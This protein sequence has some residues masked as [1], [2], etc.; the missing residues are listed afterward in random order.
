MWQKESFT[1]S[2]GTGK[3]S[4]AS[5]QSIFLNCGDME[6]FGFTTPL[7]SEKSVLL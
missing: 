4:R 2:V 1:E 7:Y 6:H 3:D 5:A